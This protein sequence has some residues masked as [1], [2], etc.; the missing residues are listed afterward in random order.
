MTGEPGA[1]GS[2]SR[3]MNLTLRARVMLFT[4][5]TVVAALAIFVVPVGLTL[6]ETVRQNAR[7]TAEREVE[8]I[9]DVIS[10]GD[11]SRTSLRRVVGR[12]G[13]RDDDFPVAVHLPDGTSV[14]SA[15]VA[16]LATADPEQGGHNG[17][18]GSRTGTRSS[19]MVTACRYV[20]VSGGTLA[21][22]DVHTSAGESRV[23]AYVADSA[24]TTRL[25][26]LMALLVGAAFALMAV[27][28]VAAD[29]MSRR[30]V[31]QLGSAADT[32]DRLGEG[33]LAARVAE[34]GPSEVRRVGAALNRLAGRIDE[35]LLAE[36]ETVAD[37]SHRLR[38][39]LTAVRLDV[40]ALPDSASKAELEDHLDVLERTLTAVIRAARRPQREGARARCDVRAVVADR[41]A[42]WT[43][44]VE[45]QG[46]EFT[47]NAAAAEDAELS[48][49]CA[50]EDLA[51][52]LDALLEN[53]VAHTP[54]GTPMRVG[55]H[56]RDEF[57][58]VDV[59]DRG[60]GVPAQAL[61]RGR[62]DRGSSGLGLDIARACAEASGGRL[63]L[64]RH[65]G[66]AIVR[67]LLGPA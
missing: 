43:P 28:A 8:S 63:E 55:V 66:W 29:R 2:G 37:L 21:N 62:S 17:S 64:V 49:R 33:D 22:V 65:D 47:V 6:H 39:P 25:W 67:L 19:T 41:V 3:R 15:H 12:V 35:L 50:S 52:A 54:E 24:V 14:G 9:A 61:A 18:P 4:T 32:A 48:A 57:I 30:I 59:A 53:C 13:A 38:T 7:A 46:R 42:F 23:F 51:V 5:G 11:H 36:R 16:E 34:S 58:A 31:R 60:E 56:Q 45:D 27:A 20:T 40:E 1:D 44:L 26:R 10:S